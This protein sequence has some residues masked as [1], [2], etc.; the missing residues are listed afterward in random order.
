MPKGSLEKN[1]RPFGKKSEFSKLFHQG[2]IDAI[3]CCFV[4]LLFGIGLIMMYSASYA[5]AGAYAT[6]TSYYFKKQLMWGAL[7]LVAMIVISRVDYRILNSW[8]TPCFIIPFSVFLMILALVM[9]KGDEIQRW[10]QIGPVSIQPS[11]LMKFVTVLTMAY[12]ICILSDT[13]KAEKGSHVTPKRAR[14][15]RMEKFIYFLIDTPFKSSVFM[16]GII[17]S[18]TL[19]VLIGKHLSGAILVCL[20]GISM[21]WLSGCPKWVMGLIGAAAVAAIAIVVLKPDVLKLF[22]D[23]AYER[24][25]VWKTKQS[26][27]N[28]TYWQ[29]KQ[30]LLAIGSG[31]PFGVG[32]GNSK[33]KLLY[34]PEPQNDFVFTIV[35]EELGYVGAL[36]ILI[37]F[38]MLIVRGFM[39]ATKTADYFGS[40]L[41]IGIMMQ[42]GLQVIIN[43]AVITDIFPNTGIPFPFFSAGGSALFILLCE[44]G[45]VLSVSRKSY[46]DKE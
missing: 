31:G 30:G 38:A 36:I 29:T 22:S 19:L 42:V 25:V 33:Q 40:L 17:G 14:L 10:I 27:G 20:I 2:S 4:V 45:V 46:L 37:F 9:N 15:T 39:I 3:F 16:V 12:V 32:L 11:E 44:M 28:T 13:L 21:L 34:V 43:I 5:Y 7:G 8:F 18:Y 6:S 35:C 26:V 23:Y 24:I 1:K 41:I